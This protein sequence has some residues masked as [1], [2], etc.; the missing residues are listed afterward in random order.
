MVSILNIRMGFIYSVMH[1]LIILLF[2]A[3]MV[4]C[5]QEKELREQLRD[6]REH[7]KVVRPSTAKNLKD[8]AEIKVL[9]NR[10][11]KALVTLNDLQSQNKT[12]RKDIDVWRKELRNQHRV[13]KGYNREINKSVDDIKKL[14]Q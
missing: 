6:K 13:N 11:D 12:L 9:E 8:K 2:R 3:F 14:N 10:C 7:L 1:Q 4:L 5:D